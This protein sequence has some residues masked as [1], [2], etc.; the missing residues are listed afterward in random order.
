M[1]KRKRWGKKYEDKR[2]W[3]LYNKQ[4]IKRGEFYINPSFLETWLDEIKEM[5]YGKVGEPYLYPHSLIDF[6]AILHSKGFDYIDLDPFGS[7]NIFLDSAV[8]RL[9]RNGILAV[10]ATDTA[11]NKS[12]KEIKVTYNP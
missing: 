1:P 3:K 2:D 12:E 4:L 6:L 9:G 5:N 7:P 11:G 8:K 10:T